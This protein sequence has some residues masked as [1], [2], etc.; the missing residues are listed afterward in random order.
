[1]FKNRYATGLAFLFKKKY[2]ISML[3]FLAL[4]LPGADG[5]QGVQINA[6]K[7][8]PTG[9]TDRLSTAISGGL[10]IF[11]II[12]IVLCLISIVRAGIQWTASSGDKTKVASARARL[13]WS[14]VGLIV[15]LCAFLIVNILGAFFSVNLMK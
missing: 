9:G 12:A 5:Q 4:T 6:P 1:M 7:S 14:I 11:L 13:T 3:E 8:I 10:T 15:V 2:G